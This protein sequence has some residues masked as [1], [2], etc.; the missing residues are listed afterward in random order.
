M[1]R[2]SLDLSF[3]K[4]IGKM[5]EIKGGVKVRRLSL[6]GSV[7]LER[8]LLEIDLAM[9]DSSVEDKAKVFQPDKIKLLLYI[10]LQAQCL[11]AVGVHE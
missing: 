3:S 10:Q 1:P 5:V 2:N 6:H 7:A 9:D 8:A 4:K 11:G